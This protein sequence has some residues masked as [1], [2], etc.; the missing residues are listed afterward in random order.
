M[1]HAAEFPGPFSLR[2]DGTIRLR[3]QGGGALHVT[4]RRGE[5]YDPAGLERINRLFGA[6]WQAETERVSLR[7]IELLD[8]LQ[9][10]FREAAFT[11]RSGYRSPTTNAALRARG[12]LAAQSSLHMEGEAVDG[13]FDGVSA[14][15]VFAYVKGLACCGIGY[16]HGRE[17]HLDTGPPRYWDETTSGT[18]SREPQ[19]NAKI[20]VATDRD[21]YRSGERATLRFMRITDYP[22][23]VP[24]TWTMEWQ[25]LDAD[26]SARWE[27]Q[28]VT[29]TFVATS[30][31][32]AA[33][34]DRREAK[35]ATLGMAR[36]P[37]A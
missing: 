24:T 23:R 8:H 35:S 22:I 2:G 36:P 31:T 19:G 12:R 13:H 11:L 9:D 15:D 17:V 37:R 25:P 26:P 32:C 1:A 14:A 18:E 6:P 28:E 3:A 27:R 30:D 7:L 20:M 5:V 29:P 4:F 33:L 34:R 16:Y 10:H 21:R